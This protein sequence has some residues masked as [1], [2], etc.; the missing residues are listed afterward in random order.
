MSDV[1]FSRG[2]T[3]AE[4]VEKIVAMNGAIKVLHF[5]IYVPEKGLDETDIIQPSLTR[6]IYHKQLSAHTI[7]SLRREELITD[8]IKKSIALLGAPDTPSAMG[9]Y[10]SVMVGDNTFH[11]TMMD[12][13]GGPSGE[14]ARERLTRIYTF[15]HL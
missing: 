10:S 2:M 7:L 1:R 12:F 9:V 8:R 13:Y 15:L 11:I 3:A 4:V 6:L 5:P 14:Y